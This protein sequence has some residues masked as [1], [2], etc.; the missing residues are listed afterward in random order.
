MNDPA[1]TAEHR[2]I[3]AI[4]L[5]A[6]E[7]VAARADGPAAGATGRRHRA[8]VPGAGRRLR[9]R[10]AGL[11][12]RPGRRRLPLPDPPRPDAVRRALPAPRPAGSAVR[13][14]A[15]DARHRRLQAADLAGPGGVDPRR[16]PRRRAAHAAGPRLHRRRRS[17][18]RPR[19][20]RA[21]RHDVGVPREA[22]PRPHRGAAA[23]RRVHPRCRRGRGPR[24]RLAHHAMPH[25]PERPL[26]EQARTRPASGC[27]RC[28][29]PAATAAGGCART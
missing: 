8:L 20:G 29:R 22:R 18:P 27:R 5:V 21:V 25:R 2:A 4:V 17:R 15:G 3:E 23:D 16:R 10:R 14:G 24:G 26:W 13:R 9:G 6:S 1:P 12:A 28:W 19:P 11:P 7:P